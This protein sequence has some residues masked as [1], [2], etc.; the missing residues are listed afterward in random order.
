MIDEL[1]CVW[2]GIFSE[3]NDYSFGYNE[4]LYNISFTQEFANFVTN[5]LSNSSTK[6]PLSAKNDPK[7]YSFKHI[8]QL[9]LHHNDPELV[10]EAL[11]SLF[12]LRESLINVFGEVSVENGFE[13]LLRDSIK[14]IIVDA[15]N[16]KVKEGNSDY[17]PVLLDVSG[18]KHIEN[19]LKVTREIMS[20]VNN[21]NQI[22]QKIAKTQ[23]K[24]EQPYF[25]LFKG[26]FKTNLRLI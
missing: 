22:N 6:D 25:I 13:D 8:L 4:K 2:N 11:Q 5:S 7:P 3:S 18:V 1:L 20:L 9:I 15:F 17:A 23:Q 26:L 24:I 21:I 14:L 19:Y 10:Q 12:N 16:R